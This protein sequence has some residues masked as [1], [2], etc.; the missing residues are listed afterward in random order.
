M[1]REVLLSSMLFV[2]LLIVAA[3]YALRVARKGRP[4]FDRIEQQG[5]TRFLGKRLMEM[6]Y[7]GLQPMGQLMIRLRLSP[8][9]ISMI[10]LVLGLVAGLC[11]GQGAF[12]LAA[13]VLAL[14]SLL[15]VVDGMVARLTN[16]TSEV[17][18][19]LDTQIDR[20]T[21]F[22]FLAGVAVYYRHSAALLVLTLVA[23][24]GCYLV[25]YTTLMARFKRFD[26]P[27]GSVF[28]R[29]AERVVYLILG[30][31]LSP[32]SIDTIEPAVAGHPVGYP[33]GYPIGYPMALAIGIIAAF[34]NL[35]AV[36][37][38]LRLMGE[39]RERDRDNER[40]RRAA[41]H[42]QDIVV[43]EIN[44]REANQ[45]VKPGRNQTQPLELK[46]EKSGDQRIRYV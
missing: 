36:I 43:V 34:A 15:D 41:Q 35:S 38:L 8:N 31:A 7:W 18:Y 21:E 33:I 9:T 28:M 39:M 29:R 16:R 14:S 30:A 26:L 1:R 45:G 12:G 6:G 20:Y 23:L 42:V 46:G 22:F 44:S 11:V 2:F 27:P 10:A 4:R 13:L 17:G 40:Q 32:I 5:G 25:S 3:G 19:V 24:L 37:Q